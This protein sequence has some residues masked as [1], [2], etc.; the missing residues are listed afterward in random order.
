MNLFGTDGI[1][2]IANQDLSC[3]K[4]F[5]LGRAVGLLL[6]S[7]KPIGVGKDTRVSSDM[8]EAALTAG[9]ASTG[10]NVVELGVITTPGLSYIIKHFDLGGGVMISA[11]HNSFEYNGLKV[12]GAD[13][14]K[15]SDE[16]EMLYSERIM[17]PEDEGPWPTGEKIGRV[18][19]G[20]HLVR[21]YS[22][23]LKSL[24]GV[25][26]S[27]LR[28]LVDTANGS[29]SA[30]ARDVWRSLCPNADFMNFSPDGFNINLECGSTHPGSLASHV[31]EGGYDAGFAYDGDGDRCIAV[32]E[33]GNVINGDKLMGVI[34]L[35]MAQSGRLAHN[36]VVGTVMSNYGLERCLSSYGI[37]LVRTQVGDRFVLEEMLRGGYSLGGEQ[38]GHIIVADILHAGDGIVTSL[39]IGE[40]LASTESTFS[41]LASVVREIPQVL[42]NVRAPFPGHIV[43]LPRVREAVEKVGNE[44]SGVGRVLVRASGTEP[45]VRIMVE[46]E[47]AKIVDE[48]VDYLKRILEEEINP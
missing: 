43:N 38:S 6:P 36:T 21:S 12:F 20:N 1:R 42:V 41:E 29:T 11:S 23:F 33:Q 8:L 34:G 22:D 30:I 10:R 18:I 26:L 16:T 5:R 25:D 47:D 17:S 35:Y 37:R 24:P 4:A 28:I 27:D 14:T 31:I 7:D 13:G 19:R 2:G 3:E 32:D 46:S 39:C 9:I 44:L 15:I 40:I 48:C 45:V